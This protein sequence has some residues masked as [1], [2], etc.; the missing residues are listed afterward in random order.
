M[1]NSLNKLGYCEFYS[2]TFYCPVYFFYFQ[3][4]FLRVL[5]E[6]FSLQRFIEVDGF[7]EVNFY[8]TRSWLEKIV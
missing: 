5:D 6:W 7:K 2:A 1:S 4:Q 3:E 8:F